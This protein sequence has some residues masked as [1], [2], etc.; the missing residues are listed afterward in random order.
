MIPTFIL[1][2]VTVFCVV[3][4]IPGSVID[5]MLAEMGGRAGEEKLTRAELEA[6]LG[7]DTPIHIQYGHWLMGVFRGDLGK[8]LWTKVPV[9][10]EIIARLPIS[11]ELGLLALGIGLLIALPVGIYSGIRQD[12]IG[13]YIGRTVAIL[14]IS[15][16]TFWVGT[17]VVVYPSIWL[18]WS[19]PVQYIPFAE[20][21]LEN[22]AQ[23]VIPASIMGMYMSGTTMR[24]TRTMMLEVLRQDYIRTAWSKGLRETAIVTGHAL[25]NALIPVI[26][27]VGMM[28]P[29]L[30][31]GS[32]IMEQ[33]FCLPGIGRLLV[34]A[35][36]KR[37]YPIISGVNLFVAFATL[38]IN[39][40][41]DLS[42]AYINP[43]I[44]YR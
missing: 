2:T 10:E 22:L 6:A 12:T 14:F 15:L 26:T 3:R 34:E 8:S 42:Y 44:R 17:M 35:L 4:F 38:I 37:N 39:L 30:I 11:L 28:L 25:R 24:M 13:D 7:L 33:I 1:V 32:V 19:P 18:G 5:Q 21:P 9:G 23:F 27:I 41:V 29:I 40:L 43:R 20:N 31:G 16:P 36:N